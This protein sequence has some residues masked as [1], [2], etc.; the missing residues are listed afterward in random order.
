MIQQRI[1]DHQ[2]LGK[3][4]PCVATIGSVLWAIRSTLHDQFSSE[5]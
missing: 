5:F 1:C 4:E 3:A 2:P